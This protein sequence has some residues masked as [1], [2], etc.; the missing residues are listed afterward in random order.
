MTDL[1]AVPGNPKMWKTSRWNLQLLRTVL[2][3]FT[4]VLIGSR[5][6]MGRKSRAGTQIDYD[7]N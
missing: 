4:V 5:I 2:R 7:S 1:T 3:L 6:V